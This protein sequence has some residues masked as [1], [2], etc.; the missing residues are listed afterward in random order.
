MNICCFVCLL[1]LPL[2]SQ[3]F[4]VP[5]V[6]WGRQSQLPTL[7]PLIGM[8]TRPSPGQSYYL[9]PLVTAKQLSL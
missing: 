4:L 6:S 2:G 8:E 5:C 9:L 7:S 1:L 3:P